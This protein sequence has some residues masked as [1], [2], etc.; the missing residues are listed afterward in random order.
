M[1]SATDKYPYK[2][3][4]DPGG[5]FVECLPEMRIASE[6]DIL[7]LIAFCGESETDRLL[8]HETNLSD[9]FYDLRTKLAGSVLLKLSNYRI[10]LAAVI[11]AERIG[12][13]KFYEMVLETNR[14]REFRVFDHRADAVNWFSTL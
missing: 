11:S 14:G 1:S 4:K 10:I 6:D 12:N 8:V 2:F 7:E 9:D 3:V 5:G 13:G